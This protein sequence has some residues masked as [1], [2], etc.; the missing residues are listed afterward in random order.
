MGFIDAHVH[1]WTD[2]TATYPFAAPHVGTEKVPVT[3]FP[4]DIL[5]HAGPC[6]VDRVVL[7]QMSYYAADNRY[8]LQVMKDHPGVF[9]GIGI[10]DWT[11]A[12]PGDDMK[13][14]ADEGVYGFRV[15][16]RDES[17][18]MWCDGP[19]FTSMFATGTDRRLAICPLIGPD[20]LPALARRCEQFPETPVIIDHL[21]RIGAGAPVN[22]SDVDALCRM[23]RYE[24]VM[25][26][27]SA[28]YALGATT[29][30]YHDLSHLI[31]RVVEA[32]GP[33]RLMWA[34][35]APYQVQGEH[36]YAASVVLIEEG[37]D[38]LGTTDREQILRGTAEGFFFRPPG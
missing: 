24:N 37:L 10:V 22:D 27:V 12:S 2:D 3:F 36:T 32:F 9:G 21:C 29:P 31:R 15:Y 19:G 23:A 17:V 14:L 35:D 33:E 18:D 1:V 16:A 26:K 11:G 34:S 7:V 5:G 38:F 13:Q 6:G 8:M 4:E 20:G 28:F 25:V 30:P